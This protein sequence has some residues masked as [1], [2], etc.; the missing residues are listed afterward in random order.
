VANEVLSDEQ[1]REIIA[2]RVSCP[3]AEVEPSNIEDARAVESAVVAALAER[4]E[5]NVDRIATAA[6]I[7]C[8]YANRTTPTPKIIA[9]AIRTALAQQVARC[10]DT[11]LDG[12]EA[13]CPAWWRGQDDGCAGMERKL[14]ES[15]VALVAEHEA[16]EEKWGELVAY[17]SFGFCKEP[18]RHNYCLSIHELRHELGV[19]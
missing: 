12:T 9:D 13:A 7:D 18:C 5:V 3:I 16:R 14:D 10:L 4:G 2:E 15:R 1:L 17:G 8:E 6:A 11:T 19:E